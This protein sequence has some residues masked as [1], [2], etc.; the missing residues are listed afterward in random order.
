M[1]SA[2]G[3]FTVETKIMHGTVEGKCHGAAYIRCVWYGT[4]INE[5]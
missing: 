1:I 4:Q 3:T 5:T 2:T